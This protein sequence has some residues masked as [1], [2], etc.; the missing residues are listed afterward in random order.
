MPNL[1]KIGS[2]KK[3]KK[4]PILSK[5]HKQRRVEWAKKYMKLD[6]SQVVFSDEYRATL[7]GPDGF[8]KGWIRHRTLPPALA[9]RQQK[10]VA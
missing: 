2:V 3:V 9:A 7:D 8:A 6:F 5:Q 4:L 1:N 10:E